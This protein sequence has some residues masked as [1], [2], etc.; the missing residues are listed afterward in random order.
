MKVGGALA[1]LVAACWV[2]PRPA[3]SQAR[4]KH[5]I[6]ID[7]FLALKLASDPRLSPD[8]KL[9]AFVVS[10]PSLVDNRNV[11]KLWLARTDRDTAWQVTNGTG[12]DRAPRWSP[13]GQ[14]LAFLAT[15]DGASQVWQLPMRGGDPVKL[16]SV[17]TGVTD[18]QW[19]ND[20][21]DLFLVSDV[22]WPAGQEIDQRNGDYP[23]EARI[24]TS[25]FYRHWNEWRAGVRQ[26]V[27]RFTLAN[28][29]LADLTPIDRDVPTIALGGG[30]LAVSPSGAELAVTYNPDSTVAT[31]TNNDIFLM[32]ADGAAR[33]A[34]T[35]NPANDHSPAYSP[36]GRLIAYL[37]MEAPG[38]ESDRQQIM[39]YEP[40]T[41]RRASLTPDW[42]LSVS[43]F[44]WLPDSRG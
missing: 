17:P 10:V 41:G 18:F 13:D 14:T 5:P 38:F 15:R 2:A 24:W 42:T 32:P 21:R 36:N 44:T 28:Q 25:L 35:T 22:K 26:H 29:T 3:L 11:S 27:L 34:I 9:V 43:A 19:S 16:T 23:T 1:L 20:G 8:G 33:R 12:T 37:A 7:D 39:L 40:G 6:G 4:S 30:D 31:S